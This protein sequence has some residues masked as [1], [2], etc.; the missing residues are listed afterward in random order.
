MPNTWTASK[1][2][3]RRL[4]RALMLVWRSAP[5]ATA[6]S[7]ALIGI[8]AALPLIGLYV[9]KLIVDAVVAAVGQGAGASASF[10]RLAGLIAVA[11]I[12]AIAGVLVGSLASYTAESLSVRVTDAM[13]DRLHEK[14]VAVDYG[15]YED[16]RYYNSL[17]RAQ[18]EAPYRPTR[19]L[20]NLTQS[21]QSA[22]TSVGIL[23]LL[24]TVHVV[25]A[26]VVVLAVIPALALRIRH[27]RRL[28]AWQWERAAME[29]QG[30]YIGWL[31]G[32]AEH[33]KEVRVFDLGNVLRQRFGALRARLSQGRLDLA[34]ARTTGEA[35]AQI[36]ASV[37]VFG[38]YAFIAYQTLQ[39]ALTV[40]DLAMYFGAV[41][42]GQSAL[43][44]FAGG[45]ASLYE[46]NLYL[47]NVDEFFELAPSIGA[48]PAPR[49]VPRPVRDGVVCEGVHFSYPGS[50]VPA[51]VDI[52]LEVR[53]GETIAL[54]G[55]N[56]SGKTTL[57]KLLCR[58][59][60]PTR[61][62]IR[63]DGAD[64]REYDPR[65]LRRHVSVVFQD[66]ARYYLSARENIWFGDVSR[67]SV[68]ERI[69][70]AAQAAGADHA[71]ERL[72]HGYD[73]T[74]GKFFPDGEELSIGEWQ[75]IALARAFL[76]DAQI[77][78]VDEPTSALD[79]TAEAEVFRALGELARNR[80]TVVISHRLST[81]RMASR[82]Y[83]LER[84]RVVEAGSHDEL[85]GQHGVY[86]RLFGAQ[87]EM[88]VGKATP[89]GLTRA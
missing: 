50:S 62:S 68:P 29:R 81:V 41:Q 38:S 9:F 1:Q 16:P 4:Q 37:V 70:E 61:G 39:G 44:G 13:L 54:V 5:K 30:N 21:I 49:P 6:V 12:I 73:T 82:I 3:F 25:L 19:L 22:I 64:L 28:N 69:R 14:S 20:S 66:Y 31:M 85:M 59:Y 18:A 7:M 46:D 80:A 34:R 58:L 83:C 33:A 86:A 11:A 56:G 40:G 78:I 26:T 24:L 60:D 57:V 27:S 15:Y 36:A 79:A 43:Q 45:I 74:L 71:I 77:L 47:S 2:S 51:L 17:H 67:P 84:G 75:K 65:E 52:S 35:T 42:R 23:V 89:G 8:Q 72:P 63:L 88:Y 10:E 32:D 76:S 48:P 55:P 87:A 53:P